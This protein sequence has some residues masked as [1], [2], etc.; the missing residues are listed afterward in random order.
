MARVPLIGEEDRPELQALIARI[1]A[2][3]G[4]RLLNLYRAL[5]NSP[6]VA[7]GWLGLFTAIRQ[8][9]RLDAA[10]RELAILRVAIL[11]RAEYEYRAHVPHALRAGIPQ[12]KIDALGEWQVC[13]LFNEAERAVLAYTDAMTQRVEVPEG[14]AAAVRR[15]FGDREL[16]E[17]TAA[18]AGYNLVSRVLV[19]LAIDHEQHV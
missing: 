4:G 13:P 7:E 18:I 2:E 5:L 6:P 8:Q 3:R 1:K 19:A 11:T 10:S 12:E 9:G 17:L 15:C 14:I 16:V